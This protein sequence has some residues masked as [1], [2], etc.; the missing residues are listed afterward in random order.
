MWKNEVLSPA[1]INLH[2]D[3]AGPG[4]KGFHP[5]RSLFL[6]VS[7]YD[8]L[9]VSEAE[10]GCR[11][12]SDCPFPAEENILYRTW[13]L[14]R[15]RGFYRGGLSLALEK[16]IPSGAGLGGG[17]SDCASLIHVLRERS[18]EGISDG[19]WLELGAELGSDV[20][21]FLRAV[22]ALV[23]GR[24]EHIRPLTAR[25]DFH[26]L[27]VYP[28]LHISTPA[29]FRTLDSYRE[30]EGITH[31][32]SLTEEDIIRI[33]EQ[34]EPGDWGFLNS[35][36]DPIYEEYPQLAGIRENLLTRGADFVTL[37]GSGSAMVGIFKDRDKSDSAY[38]LMKSKFPATYKAIPLDIIPYGIVI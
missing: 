21:F 19:Q 20:P 5:L 38:L 26:I 30:R 31:R 1:K 7:L 27:I 8:R 24:G 6:M 28:D 34:R 17:S 33:W 32:W 13:K 4:E 16:N 29:A 37:S 12:E 2:L 25:G 9:T 3:I 36:A 35:F 18:G 10:E 23:T 11:I 14:C 22:S 15:E